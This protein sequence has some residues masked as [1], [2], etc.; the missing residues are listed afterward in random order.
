GDMPPVLLIQ[1]TQDE[2]YAGT[3]AYAERLKQCGARHA[4]V[5]LE[6]APHGMENWA[7]HSEWEFY[8]QRLVDWLQEN[9]SRK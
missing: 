7:G 8:K 2:L 9:L 1:G 5:V 6:G 4:L 3:L